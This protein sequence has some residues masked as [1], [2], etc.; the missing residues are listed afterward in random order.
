MK[1]IGLLLLFLLQLSCS[2]EQREIRTALR[3]AG[4]NRPELEAVLKHYSSVGEK[5]KEQAAKYLIRYMPQHMSY[6]GDFEAF[7]SMM[8]SLLPLMNSAEKYNHYMSVITDSLKDRFKLRSDTR[9][10][11]SDFLITSIE[12]A[13]QLWKNGRW[14]AHLSFDEF[15]EYILPYKIEDHQPLEEWR[16]MY[17][18]MYRGKEVL[19]NDAIDEFRGEPEIAYRSVRW[20]AMKELCLAYSDSI[21]NTDLYDLRLLKEVPYGDCVSFCDLGLLLY[22]SK[23]MPVAKDYVPGWA[24][25]P[26]AHAWLS[27]FTRRGVSMPVNAFSSGDPIGE[28]QC[29][30]FA[31]VH[32]RTFRPNEE[33]FHRLKQGYPIPAQ[34][35]DIFFKDVTDKYVKCED[36]MAEVKKMPGRNVYAAVFDDQKWTP[37]AFGKRKGLGKVFFEKLARNALYIPVV[38]QRTG[39]QIPLGHPFFIHSDG[40]VETIVNNSRTGKATSVTMR[41]K[42]PAYWS[43]ETVYDRTRGGVFQGSNDPDF[44]EVE[45]ISSVFSD[46]NW[47]SYVQVS[48]VQSYRYY[49]FCAPKGGACDVGEIKFYDGQDELNAVSVFSPTGKANAT[50]DKDPSLVIDNDALTWVTADDN[51][52]LWIGFDF[53]KPQT[54]TGLYYSVRSDGNDFY[55]GFE[56]VL[57]QWNGKTW[58][59][60]ET[61]VATREVE[62]EFKEL[63]EGTLYLV[64]C[65]TAG[66]QSRPFVVKDGKP[67]WM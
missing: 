17:S 67:F 9:I 62:H 2:R 38:L 54:V 47:S 6:Q 41:R 58:E 7:R 51:Q 42:Y 29:R 36:V 27:I 60:K 23:G 33:I 56:Y 32:R 44:R 22:R 49:R 20:R 52:E 5:E 19:I 4:N 63:F 37:V 66:T 65:N 53:G 15:C 61:F 28:V 48:K 30:R 14:A 13:F 26:G 24:D 18:G 46:M 57:R 1:R 31:K 40:R 11:T 50:P 64:T 3:M 43:L 35:R 12:E 8:D 55:P 21:E 16:S 39:E 59:K 34:L 45:T 10:I 25:R